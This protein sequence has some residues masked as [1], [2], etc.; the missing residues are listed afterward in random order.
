MQADF[1]APVRFS[2]Q[3]RFSATAIDAY[4]AR[5]LGLAPVD[6]GPERLMDSDEVCSRLAISRRTLG[7][8]VRGRVRGEEATA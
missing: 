8:L 6:G 4:I 3:L 1:P 7:R 5:Q 2:R